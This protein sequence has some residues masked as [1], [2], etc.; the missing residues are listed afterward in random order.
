[1]K[2][3]VRRKNSLLCKFFYFPLDLLKTK[4]SKSSESVGRQKK[5]AGEDGVQS[6]LLKPTSKFS[7]LEIIS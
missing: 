7:S 3:K 6:T 1:M 2:K 4:W 5:K